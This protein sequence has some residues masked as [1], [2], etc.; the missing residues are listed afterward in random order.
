ML[1][2]LITNQINHKIYVGKTTKPTLEERW[3]EHLNNVR[4]R[5]RQQ[6]FYLYRAMKKY[7][8]EKFHLEIITEAKDES[9]LNELEKL[10]IRVL[11]STNSEIGYNMTLGGDGVILT[12]EGKAKQKRAARA[13]FL[14]P[15][16]QAHSKRLAKLVSA[17]MKD[18]PKSAEQRA[19]M[20]AHWTSER[21]ERQ[22]KIARSENAKLRNFTCPDCKKE[23][24]QITQTAYGGHRRLCL[25]LL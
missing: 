22:A 1:V 9:Q 18:K 16:G 23:F 13:R 2:Y 14:T 10:W 20:A 25:R 5:G 8:S 6:D 19:K 12:A 4:W 21:R 7:G 3:K 24:K 11:D 15:E 17:V